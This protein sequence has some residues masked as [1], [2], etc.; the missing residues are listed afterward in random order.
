MAAIRKAITEAITELVTQRD[1]FWLHSL[2][3]DRSFEE[4]DRSVHCRDA[5][6]TFRSCGFSDSLCRTLGKGINGNLAKIL[7][8][9]AQHLEV[10]TNPNRG[11]DIVL[12][13]SEVP[14]AAIE[15]KQVF[16]LTL[17]K[18]FKNIAD[19]RAKLSDFKRLYPKTA[20][21]QVVF[22]GT[23]PGAWYPAGTWRGEPFSCR[24]KYVRNPTVS[25]QYVRVAQHL[26]TNAT[27]PK[28]PPLIHQLDSSVVNVRRMDTWAHCSAFTYNDPAWRFKTG[29]YLKDAAVGAALWEY[30]V[31]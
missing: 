11:R 22:L 9:K 31:T 16:E 12:Y 20:L 10:E 8:T 1:E 6:E 3:T 25:V 28:S 29:S 4:G 17:A 14:V 24:D 27:W 13:D 2:A 23:L 5:I 19:D 26:G 15:I 21:F 7:K 30:G 18:Y